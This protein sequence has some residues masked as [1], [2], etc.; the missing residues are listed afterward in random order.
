MTR[1]LRRFLALRPTERRLFIGTW[2]ILPIIDLMLRGLGLR[3]TQRILGRSAALFSRGQAQAAGPAAVA[4][5]EAKA[6]IIAIAGRYALANG[7]CLRQALLLWWLLKRRDQAA[8]LRIGVRTENGFAA[9]AWV[10][11]DG[12][13]LG[14]TPERRNRFVRMQAFGRS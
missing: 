4:A 2:L 10:E 13:P 9:H 11:L 12:K 8:E 6:A 7:T 5:A 14:Q 3:R 1:R